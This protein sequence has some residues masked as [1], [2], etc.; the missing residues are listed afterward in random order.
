MPN[1]IFLICLFLLEQKEEKEEKST[2]RDETNRGQR[3]RREEKE[4]TNKEGPRQVLFPLPI[5]TKVG[6][7]VTM[8]IPL[9]D[10]FHPNF[11][12]AIEAKSFN[13]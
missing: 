13:C 5:A 11:I 6:M 4:N 1:V 3:G 8:E 10:H 2:L 9:M 7:S 12:V